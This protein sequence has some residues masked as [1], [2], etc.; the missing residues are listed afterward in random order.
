ME[1]LVLVFDLDSTLID[2]SDIIF[3]INTKWAAVESYIARSLNTT[4]VDKILRP[5]IQLRKSGKVSAILM[6]TN[7]MV[8]IY[9][10]CIEYYI[11]RYLGCLSERVFDYMM[12][13]Q[14]PMRDS[15]L[16]NPPKR[17]K[18]IQ[19]ILEKIGK[20]T[21]NLAAR[22]FV[23]DDSPYHIIKNELKYAGYPSNYIQITGPTNVYMRG[24]GFVNRGY[25]AGRP[26]LTNYNPILMALTNTIEIRP[27]IPTITEYYKDIISI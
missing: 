26:D 22:T 6:L 5:A 21:E 4:L 15:R 9:V 11:A 24:Y 25:M 1:G 7:N 10:D 8:D 16:I 12:L 2:S 20:P 13:R 3:Q 17:L 19:N 18:D 14:D 23:F 27:R